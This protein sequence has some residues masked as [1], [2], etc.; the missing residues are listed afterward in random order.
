[1][2][3]SAGVLRFRGSVVG[4]LRTAKEDTDT[5]PESCPHYVAMTPKTLRGYS[6]LLQAIW[7]GQSILLYDEDGC[8]PSSLIAATCLMPWYTYPGDQGPT[9]PEAAMAQVR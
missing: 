1:M 2:P 7:E 8:G 3:S 4:C 9:D 6:L 5:W